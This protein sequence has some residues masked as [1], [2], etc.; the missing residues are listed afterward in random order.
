MSDQLIEADYF[1]VGTGA[2]AMAFVDTL[3]TETDYNVVMVDR[4]HRPGGHWNDAYSFVRL[5][6]PSAIY[7]VASQKLERSVKETVGFTKGEDE[8]ASQSEIMDY[9]EDIMKQRFV[10][11]GRVRWYPMTEYRT[12]IDGIHQATAL[13]TGDVLRFKARRKFVDATHANV[14][15]P[16]THSPSFGVGA[17]VRCVPI[18]DLPKIKRPHPNYTIVGSGKT[19]MDACLWLLQHG[20]SPDKIRWIRPRD[21]WMMNRLGFNPENFDAVVESIVG[22]FEAIIDATSI[23]NLFERLEGSHN[24]VRL[25]RAVEPTT[26]RCATIS[27]KEVEQLRKISNVVRLGHLVS[28]ERD[29]LV[30]EDGRIESDPDTLYVDCSAAGVQPQRDLPVFDGDTINIL[31]VMW[32]R[33]V[34]S[35]ALIAFV[36]SRFNDEQQQNAFCHPVPSP[37]F[38]LDWV[39]MWAAS[40]ANMSKW[41][42]NTAIAEWLTTCRLEIMNALMQG[43]DPEAPN[44]QRA[45]AA[46]QEKMSEAARKLP[47]LLG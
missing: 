27:M 24:L 23:A 41:Q 43:Q 47:Q 25:D 32:C 35:A 46:M 39:T 31:W 20:V 17:G 44:V 18:N 21:H 26:Y 22:Q 11:S 12:T 29:H 28:I 2:S 13:L 14:Q 33:P 30:L 4:R 36:E 38:P 45:M 1:V 5:H 34:F 42:E 8:L 37:E 9:Y 6:G 15:I 7:G 10:G 16:S 40:F 19:S 3:L